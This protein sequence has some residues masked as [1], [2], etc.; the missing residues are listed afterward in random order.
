[1]NVILKNFVKSRIRIAYNFHVYLKFLK[2]RKNKIF[3]DLQRS[4]AKIPKRG[5]NEDASNYRQS[6][7]QVFILSRSSFNHSHNRIT[8]TQH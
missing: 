4:L 2:Y 3:R 6:I 7:K 5:K 1:M 8:Q